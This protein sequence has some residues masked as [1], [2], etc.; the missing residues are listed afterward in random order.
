VTSALVAASL[1][2]ACG[3]G[4]SADTD[5][6]GTDVPHGTITHLTHVDPSTFDDFVAKFK[7]KYPEVEDVKIERLTDYA[8]EAKTRMSTDD[9]GDVLGIPAGTNNDQLPDF[10]EPL[11]TREELSKTYRWLTKTYDGQVYGIADLGNAQGFLY[12]KKVWANAG[13]TEF[14]TT[15]EEFLDDLQ[16]IKD[17]QPDVIPFCT[18]YKD[19]W[20][21][22]AWEGYRGSVS[23]DPDYVNKLPEM[24]APWSDGHD[25]EV[26]DGLLYDIV[27]RGLIEP[28]P[29][30]ATYDETKIKIG[31]GEIAT[32]GV[33]S[34]AVARAG[35]DIAKA[36]LDP[37]DLGYMPFPAQ[38]DG[39]FYTVTGPDVTLAINKHSQNKV[40]ARAWLDF[41]EEEG[42]SAAMGGLSP[43]LDGPVPEQL[44]DF[45]DQVALFELAPAPVG[46]ESLVNDISTASGIV[47]NDG[48][49]RQQII[50]DARSGAR[51]KQQVFDDLNAAWAKGRAEVLG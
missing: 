26:M 48:K 4:S 39:T 33:G 6:Q 43:R 25:H 13:I 47:L 49:Y 10:F 1:L 50:D 20:V 7:E 29:T 30:T 8:T 17:T 42:L 19:G 41:L 22:G 18:N 40:T 11:G 15:P 24:D 44:K 37:D 27:A 23:H 3:G 36:G 5:D 35:K 16:R 38:V 45:A 31:A 14:P 2:A 21:I 34:W 51:T 9:Y 32:M 28:D 12:N 46:K